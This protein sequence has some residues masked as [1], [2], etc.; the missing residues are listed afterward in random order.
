MK[1][2]KLSA[3]AGT[4][5]LV[6]GCL[7]SLAFL[8]YF[9]M[10][11]EWHELFKAIRQAN[12]KAVGL[13]IGLFLSSYLIRALRWR[14]LLPPENPKCLD[15][16][17]MLTQ[18]FLS[19]VLNDAVAYAPWFQ[20]EDD[21]LG[22]GL[23]HHRAHVLMDAVD[24]DSQIRAARVYDVPQEGDCNLPVLR[25]DESPLLAVVVDALHRPEG[26]VPRPLRDG[27]LAQLFQLLKSL[28]L[29]KHR[30]S[31]FLLRLAEEARR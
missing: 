21:S 18:Q 6:A 15:V 19:R 8:V 10:E 2:S 9:F 28:V 27:I 16:P 1:K 5:S 25:I 4:W 31:S 7:V 14:Y 29:R 20:I 24:G 26:F 22:R 12:H 3:K 17:Q 13:G 30:L 11:V 23:G